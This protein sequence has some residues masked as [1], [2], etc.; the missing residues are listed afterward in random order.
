VNERQRDRGDL[1][2][3][4][5]GELAA[6]GTAVC[7]TGSSVAFEISGR[8][9]GSLPLNLVRLSLALLLLTGVAM[10][11]RGRA[12][13]LDVPP[14]A[15]AWLT[16]SG[17]VGFV[18]GDICLFR[19]LVIM[20][21]RVT[22]LIQATAP[23]MAALLGWAILGERP[24]AGAAVGM[25]LTS[26]GVVFVVLRG[27][28]GL[29]V[30]TEGVLLALAGALGQAGGLILAKIGLRSATAGVEIH[31]VAAT[32]VRA[33]AGVVG[34]VLVHQLAAAWPRLR[35]GVADRRALGIAAIGALLGPCLGVS[36]SLF[37][38]SR[39]QTGIAASLMA[40]TP[41]L[42]L[43]VSWARGERVSSRAV[44][45][46]LAAVAGVALLFTV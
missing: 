29:Q 18:F 32:Q 40:L 17:L 39:T 28:D 23:A 37:A 5:I 41:I 10:L 13:P 24:G 15:W 25:A 45:G 2:V 44:V 31:P 12:L 19:A 8:R 27:T 36:L 43:P 46:T 38:V 26:A 33:L 42:L 6:L 22:M 20:G 30:T 14:P 34:F 35:A 1:P 11:A 4:H 7:W 9:M 3:M 21:V 16:V